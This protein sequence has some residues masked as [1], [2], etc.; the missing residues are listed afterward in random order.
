MTAALANGEKIEIKEFGSFSIKQ[1][2]SYTGMNP[3]TGE[4]TVVKAKKL[5]FFKGR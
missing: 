3:K 2:D 5:P 1:Y 4:K